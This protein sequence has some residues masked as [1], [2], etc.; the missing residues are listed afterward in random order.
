MG[1]EDHPHVHALPFLNGVIVAVDALPRAFL[2]VDG[3]Y[4]V[5]TKAEMQTCHNLR[6]DLTPAFG[7]SRVI[8]TGTRP[9]VEVE[10]VTSLVLD[11]TSEVEALVAEVARRP[12]ADVV[13]VTAFDVHDLVGL[14]L[15]EVAARVGVSTG[16]PVLYLPC[17][18]LR[19]DWLD[20]YASACEALARAIP[21]SPAPGPNGG[22]AVVGHLM[23]RDEP[24]QQANL[25]EMRRLLAGLGRTLCAVWLD[26]EGLDGLARVQE[27]GVIA[28]L[29]YA[30][31]AAR[32]LGE[33]L[34]VPVVEV[35]LP[36][37]L[38]ATEE[39][40]RRI[41]V[42]T[43]CE[44]GCDALIESEVA[45][46]VRDA[47]R[48]VDRFV[49]GRPVVLA[50]ADPHLREG[51]GSFCRDVGAIPVR[52]EEAFPDP[53]DRAPAIPGAVAFL[54]STPDMELVPYPVIPFGYPNYLDHPIHPRPFL[55]FAGFRTLVEAVSRAALQ[56]RERP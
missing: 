10:A 44:D 41:A 55:G 35:P 20:G 39:F 16:K 33:R 24:D 13:F 22:V 48:H 1:F 50:I 5:Q 36:V 28:A 45:A 6:S 32:V 37:G 30:R 11:R 51:L 18:S 47:E 43:G 17:L 49:A 53:D 2:V 12:E 54:S 15:R 21:L 40:L 3:P 8:H 52:P 34:G 31:G 9:Q 26:G 23:D 46:A 27:A 38:S 4:C 29:P 7:Y 56:V 19:G 14:P 42:A 25:S